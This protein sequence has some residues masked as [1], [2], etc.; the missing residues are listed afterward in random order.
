MASPT[1][2]C[3]TCSATLEAEG[4]SHACMLGCRSHARMLHFGFAC[5]LGLVCC[6]IGLARQWQ[7]ES[8]KMEGSE[9]H[10]VSEERAVLR[11]WL[12]TLL[13][14]ATF[15]SRRYTHCRPCP[16]IERDGTVR[17]LEAPTTESLRALVRSNLSLCDTA[18]R[19]P[20]R[21][22]VR[23]VTCSAPILPPCS[24]YLLLVLLITIVPG[25]MH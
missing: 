3:S 19:C 23:E 13:F 1:Q 24:A 10:T 9:E 14:H 20:S 12:Y 18:C 17:T 16:V 8:T 2:T 25:S 15:G 7:R 21:S 4:G 5:W 6:L 11:E 22:P